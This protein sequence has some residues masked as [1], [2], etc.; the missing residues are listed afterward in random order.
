MHIRSSTD[1][2]VVTQLISLL[3]PVREW[4]TGTCFNMQTSSS[5]TSCSRMIQWMQI[6][7]LLYCMRFLFT[8]TWAVGARPWARPVSTVVGW[9]RA[10]ATAK[11]QTTYNTFSPT[12][13]EQNA[14]FV[15]T[16]YYSPIPVVVL[17]VSVIAVVATVVVR[18]SP[19]PAAAAAT[20]TASSS[21]STTIAVEIRRKGADDYQA[22]FSIVKKQHRVKIN[23]C[24]NKS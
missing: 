15:L 24:D 18:V 17:V 13:K 22:S 11:R 5:L 10:P 2:E 6:G 1:S 20:A 16:N 19:S 3:S 4:A 12:Q 9:R 23:K 21:S 8:L 14:N 7:E